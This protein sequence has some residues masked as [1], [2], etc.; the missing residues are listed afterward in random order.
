ML[1]GQTIADLSH[2]RKLEL[3]LVRLIEIVGEAASRVSSQGRQRYPEIPWR[4]ASG[5]R[6]RLIH[7]YDKVD[8][9]LLW[10]T[11]QAD[12]P[13][14]ITTLEKILNDAKGGK[15]V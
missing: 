8:L 2:D 1:G 9:D 12:L 15:N 14:L 4:E 13:S 5:M 3:S 11:V 7:G 10:N 6:N